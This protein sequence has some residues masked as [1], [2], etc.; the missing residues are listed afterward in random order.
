MRHYRKLLAAAGLALALPVTASAGQ[1]FNQTFPDNFTVYS[2]CTGEFVDVQG[3]AHFME[4]STLANSGGGQ[5]T[6]HLNLQGS[7]VGE[8]TGAKYVY[9]SEFTF[10]DVLATGGT[11]SDT[12]PISSEL[13][14]Q[15]TGPNL[16]ANQIAH[17][18][19]NPDGTV[20]MFFDHFN[21]QCA[22]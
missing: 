22:G 17:L 6:E 20:L 5:T 15:G 12:E 16:I 14:A 1:V 11:V 10:S 7:A 19:I 13:I 2:P 3:T 4:T 9:D 21:T 8:T 18:T